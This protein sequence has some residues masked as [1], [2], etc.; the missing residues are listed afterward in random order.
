M[1]QN[2]SSNHGQSKRKDEMN[3]ALNNIFQSN[4]DL[5]PPFI[6]LSIMSQISLIVTLAHNIFIYPWDAKL[7]M[8]VLQV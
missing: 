1:C 8:L 5:H 6:H 7:I 2:N 4:D 3:I